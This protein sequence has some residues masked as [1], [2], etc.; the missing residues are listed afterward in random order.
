MKNSITLL[1]IIHF[2]SIKFLQISLKNLN[3]EK[4]YKEFERVEKKNAKYWFMINE[5]VWESNDIK[6]Q[7]IIIYNKLYII[8][9]T[10]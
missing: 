4:F 5:K 1:K 9:N 6:L 10:Q 8:Y 3:T 7:Y 2:Q